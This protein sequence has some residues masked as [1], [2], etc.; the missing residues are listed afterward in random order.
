M[1]LFCTLLNSEERDLSL[2]ISRFIFRIILE[3]SFFCY[4]VCN[5]HETAVICLKLTNANDYME[6]FSYVNF[7]VR[8]P[9]I[10]NIWLRNYI[11]AA[12]WKLNKNEQPQT[13]RNTEVRMMEHK[14]IRNTFVYISLQDTSVLQ[15]LSLILY[16]SGCCNVFGV[17]WHWKLCYRATTNCQIK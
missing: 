6:S 7:T 14:A 13:T 12:K 15:F 2:Y 4:F 10:W 16:S 5:L 3:L 8:I 17:E 11:S 1:T 9:L